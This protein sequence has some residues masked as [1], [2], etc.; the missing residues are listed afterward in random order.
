[1]EY[2]HRDRSISR[3]R[4]PFAFVTPASR[5]ACLYRLRLAGDR[6]FQMDGTLVLTRSDVLQTLT[7]EDCMVA[8]EN[9][10]RMYAEGKTLVTGV[11]GIP[12]TGGGFHIK[13]AGLKENQNFFVTKINANFPGNPSHGLPTIQGL[14]ALFD[15]L[16]GRP[17]AVLDS[18]E[19]TSLR[20][21]AATAVAAKYL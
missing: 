7:P 12:S 16:N 4:F 3:N 6:I 18:M 13:A 15:S 5:G 17:L 8:V 20:T 2:S 11:L 1:M 21:A 10:F 14:V 19:I 9:A